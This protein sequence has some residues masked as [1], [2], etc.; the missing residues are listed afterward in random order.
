M[1]LS[2]VFS[3]STCYEVV[4]T[5]FTG[6]FEGII[7]IESDGQKGV[8]KLNQIENYIIIKSFS[9]LST[10]SNGFPPGS[11]YPTN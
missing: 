1:P 7:A 3:V 4:S 8:I 6:K 5:I 11:L 9:I 2:T 10:G